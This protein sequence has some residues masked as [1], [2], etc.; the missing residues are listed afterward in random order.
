MS[1]K[2]RLSLA[3]GDYEITRPLI[4]GRV[5]PAGVELV[6]VTPESRER[7]WRVA[8]DHAYDICE[9]NTPAYFMGRDRGLPYVSLPIYLHRR[10]RH[11]FLFVNSRKGFKAP[12]DLKGKRIAGTNYS[13]ASNI[14]MRG[15]LEQY[16][17]LPHQSVTWVTERDEDIP[18]DPPKGL[19]IEK[20]PQGGPSLE[21][22]VV[23]GELD[24]L[25]TPSLPKPFMAGNPNIKRL[26]DN[27][28]QVEIDYWKSTGIFPIMHVTIIR[29][30]IVK[31]NP[32]VGPSLARAFDQ[33]KALAYGRARN[34]RTYPL[35]WHS[36]YWD[37]QR[38]LLG[39]DPWEY[40]LG[41]TNRNNLETILRYTHQQGLISRPM[42]VDELF[43]DTD[44][45]GYGGPGGD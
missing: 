36:S 22:R 31:Q 14:W 12:K 42:T 13:P 30:E 19:K 27:Y 38:E 2:L 11:G 10:F 39:G 21:D 32:W 45:T 15:I 40:G 3:C 28:R 44:E 6:V 5:K 43:V 26:F 17:E 33:A 8:R 34:P 35:V 1:S 24:G 23:S 20:L 4:D 16:W 37:E 9:F 41:P 29:E 18:F 7:H 25:L